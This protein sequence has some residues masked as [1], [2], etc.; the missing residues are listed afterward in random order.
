[1]ASAI[2]RLRSKQPFTDRPSQDGKFYLQSGYDAAKEWLVD[3][4]GYENVEINGESDKKT[5]VFG[6]PAYNYEGGQR[7]G[8]VKTYLQSALGRPNFSLVTGARVTRVT[9]DGEV[10]KGVDVVMNGT[11]MTIE[12][13]K[14]GKVVLSG[15]AL[16]SP[17]LLMLSGIGDPEV[18]TNLTSNGLLKLSP[19]DWINN[20]AVGDKLFDNPNT[21]IE[22]FS[23]DISSY[24]YSYD[25]PPTL[26]RELYL[27][28]RSGPYS[29]ASQTSAFWDY[30]SIS[31]GNLGMQGTID[32][33]GFG[34]FKENGTITLNIYGTSG[35]RSLGKVILDSKGIPG[36]TS[37]FY[38]DPTDATAIATF[39]HSI[40]AKLPPTLKVLNAP[41]NGTVEDIRKWITTK[42][43]YTIGN[44]LHF[45]SS[46][47]IG[48]VVETNAKVIGTSNLYVIDASISEPLSVN[49]VF[50]IMAIAER[51]VELILGGK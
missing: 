32:S 13:C 44:V 6:R 29:F 40:F 39:I 43:D 4:A 47:R 36:A 22:L 35:L 7:S 17:Q 15:G 8:P 24:E 50:G 30:V 27:N 48:T 46:L 19:N 28:Q 16:F 51:A 20:T 10:A 25:N 37:F 49:P 41:Q 33:S 42:S 2:G 18:L 31:G 26:D 21:F 11:E 34:D 3:T 12:V 45:S 1:M 5:R 14:T 23:K 38:S 9:R